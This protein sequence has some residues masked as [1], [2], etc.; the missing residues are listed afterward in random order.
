MSLFQNIDEIGLNLN[1][2]KIKSLVLL[3]QIKLKREKY[4]QNADLTDCTLHLFVSTVTS[5]THT[6]TCSPRDVCARLSS[7]TKILSEHQHCI[8]INES[9]NDSLRESF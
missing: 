7:N 8:G 5:V 6:H 2:I 3:N 1:E 4:L 9:A